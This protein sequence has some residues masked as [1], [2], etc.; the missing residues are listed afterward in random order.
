MELNLFCSHE[1]NAL[2]FI[3]RSLF[4]FIVSLGLIGLTG[5]LLVPR[6]QDMLANRPGPRSFEPRERTWQVSTV[7]ALRQDTRVRVQSFGTVEAGRSLR[8]K[9]AQAGEITWISPQLQNGAFIAKGTTLLRLDAGDNDRA[10]EDLALEAQRAEAGLR[11]VRQQLASE[12]RRLSSNEDQIAI[13]Q[14]ERARVQ[15]LLD[16]GFISAA[17][18]ESADRALLQAEEGQSARLQTITALE[19]RI[20][21]SEAALARTRLQQ[22][23]LGEDTADLTLA[24]PFAGFLADVNAQISQTAGPQDVIARLIDADGFQVAFDM[25]RGE[26]G[27]LNASGP[28][29][30]RSVEATWQ[31]GLT[32]T[33]LTGRI[34]ALNPE[35]DARRGG[36]GLIARLDSI[37]ADSPLRPGALVDI[38]VNGGLLEDVIPVPAEALTTV[39]S[40]F[41]LNADSRLEEVQVQLVRREGAQAFVRPVAGAA[42]ADET[43]IVTTRFA[44]IGPGLKV[45]SA[46]EAARKAAEQ[47]QERSERGTEAEET[48]AEDADNQ[49]EGRAPGG[50]GGRD[51]GRPG[52]GDTPDA[53]RPGR[54][55]STGPGGDTVELSAETRQ[56]L[57]AAIEDSRMPDNRKA[58]VLDTLERSVVPRQV[59]QRL[60]DRTG[61]DVPELKG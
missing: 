2:R 6:I 22:D 60:S 43:E 1:V 35:I 61:I 48:E 25:P 16:S 45:V 26:F 59:L 42:L 36:I 18:L 9:P 51:R 33:Q 54:G 37:G 32:E 24:A 13:A 55:R 47:A 46:A 11:E 30:G 5:F 52:G 44:Q 14:R 28:V 50:R 58:R 40:L 23:K 39:P 17:A 31:L 4:G 41:V 38:T 49:P 10:R 19:E 15:T 7:P 57:I 27:M 29:V 56:K 53:D 20:K 34:T 21:Q 8:L 3:L 12:R